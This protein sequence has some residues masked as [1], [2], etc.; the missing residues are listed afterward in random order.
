MISLSVDRNGADSL[1]RQIYDQIRDLILGGRIAPATR[2]PSSRLLAGDL[3]VSRNTVLNAYEMLLHE[4]YTEGR[5]GD[6]TRVSQVLPEDLLTAKRR[7]PRPPRV[8][9]GPAGKLSRLR[10]VWETGERRTES[11]QRAFRPGLPEIELFPWDVWGRLSGRFW[12]RPPAE[13]LTGG[14]LAGYRPLRDAVAAYLSAV[15]GLDCHGGQVMITAG[16]QQGLDMIAR[17]IID[18]GD[19]VWLEQP[20]YGGLRAAFM[21]AGA[22]AIAVPV[23]DAGLDVAAGRRAA[24]EAVC[25]AVTPSH[26]Y[27]LG[28]TMSLARRLELLEWAASAGAW[29]VEDDYDSE[30]RYGGRPLSALQGL[31]GGGRVIYVGTFSKV[32]FPALRLGY[33]VAPEAL[34]EAFLKLRATIDDHPALAMQP[35]LAAFFEAGHF[36]A[37]VR[38]M[39][40][41]Y[42]ERQAAL[43]AALERHAAGLLT[44][45]P[46]DAGMHL[47]VRLGPAFAGDDRE[48]AARAAA[49]GLRAPALSGYYADGVSDQQGLVLGYAG[50]TATEIDCGV[51]TL[52]ATLK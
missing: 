38:R 41:L 23:D 1:H 43:L 49:A 13:L 22:R 4:G 24:P 39:R 8:A 45:A 29:I 48:A 17:L 18:P 42:A 28:V 50:L 7:G 46:D 25:A 52:A 14:D 51:A 35:V 26:Q 6:G 33:V 21:A 32:L 47:V 34:V 31:D 9:A 37:H 20:G 44:A 30:Y 15:R 10:E 19:A 36:A 2:L 12:R 3:G 40:G 11:P 16:A 5:V 27:P